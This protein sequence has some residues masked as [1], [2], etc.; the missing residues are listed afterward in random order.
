VSRTRT[1]GALTMQVLT[2][3]TFDDE[4][5]RDVGM[6]RFVGWHRRKPNLATT[7]C[8]A[9]I[10]SQFAPL[11]REELTDRLCPVCFTRSE[12]QDAEAA[13]AKIRDEADNY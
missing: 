6:R 3:A 4:T 7:S 2:E 12:R 10:A 1:D 13:A 9:P 5:A 8:G 11:R